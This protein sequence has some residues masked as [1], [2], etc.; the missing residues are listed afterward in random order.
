MASKVSGLIQ[1]INPGNNTEYSI[2]STAYGYC[3]TA[4]ATVAKTCEMTGFKLLEGTTIYIKFKYDNTASNPTLNVNGTGAKPIVQYG[5]TSIGTTNSASGWYAGAVL[6][7]TYDGTSW[8]CN[9]GL[10]SCS[11]TLYYWSST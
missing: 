10:N 2:A 5:T 11:V 7:L 4:A 1:K 3:E 6:S 8:V 9:Q